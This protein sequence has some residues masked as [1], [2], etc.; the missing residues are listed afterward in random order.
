MEQWTLD[1]VCAWLRKNKFGTLVNVFRDNN[2]D[3]I[4]LSRLTEDD[5][6]ELGVRSGL[7]Q[8]RILLSIE[9]DLQSEPPEFVP[10]EDTYMDVRTVE[11]TQ[12][13]PAPMEDTYVDIDEVREQVRALP[14]ASSQRRDPP[15]QEQEEELYQELPQ[16]PAPVAPEE[17]TYQELPSR[18]PAA[19]EED[20][21]LYDSS[22]YSVALAELIAM[23][24]SLGQEAIERTLRVNLVMF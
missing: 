21:G 12:R 19:M 4:L 9:K 18:P 14:Q 2:V 15:A 6:V 23:F 5:L 3:G 10:A 13:R 11:S 24:P 20:T 7:L 17:E 1:D 8:K 16:H 22:R